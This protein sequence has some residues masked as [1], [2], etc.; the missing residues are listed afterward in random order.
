MNS[1]IKVIKNPMDFGTLKRRYGHGWY[2]SVSHFLS[3]FKLIFSNCY[4]FNNPSTDVHSMARDLEIF[5]RK[6]IEPLE[7]LAAEE[8]KSKAK[9][10]NIPSKLPDS[11][12]AVKDKKTKP[13]DRKKRNSLTPKEKNTT[14]TKNR[15]TS[16]GKESK[17]ETELPQKVSNVAKFS[18]S[19]NA[20][21]DSRKNLITSSPKSTEE[22]NSVDMKRTFDTLNSKTQAHKYSKKASLRNS[23]SPRAKPAIHDSVNEANE[24]ATNGINDAAQN[25]DI[26]NKP[27]L[28]QYVPQFLQN[29]YSKSRHN[30]FDPFL[31]YS[32]KASDAMEMK[33]HMDCQRIL[34]ILKHP[35]L[36][37]IM[38]PFF[39][40][41]PETKY[42]DLAFIECSLAQGHYRTLEEFVTAIRHIFMN[43]ITQFDRT[44]QL[45]ELAHL[46]LEA[47]HD[48]YLNIL[49]NRQSILSLSNLI[50]NRSD[51][52][53]SKDRQATISDNSDNPA[54]NQTAEVVDD[55][56]FIFKSQDSKIDELYEFLMRDCEAAKNQVTSEQKIK[57]LD[58]R[59]S[60]VEKQ[61]STHKAHTNMTIDKLR[62]RISYLKSKQ[63]SDLIFIHESFQVAV[64]KVASVASPLIN[65][66]LMLPGGASATGSV[67]SA[68]SASTESNKYFKEKFKNYT[69]SK[70]IMPIRELDQM[71]QTSRSILLAGASK[72]DDEEESSRRLTAEEKRKLSHDINR[73]SQKML[74]ELIDIIAKHEGLNPE[75]EKELTLDYDKMKPATLRTVQRFVQSCIKRLPRLKQIQNIPVT[76]FFSEISTTNNGSTRNTGSTDSQAR[77]A[78]TDSAADISY[79]SCQ[80]DQ[81]VQT[82]ESEVRLPNYPYFQNAQQA[83]ANNSFDKTTQTSQNQHVQN[84]LIPGAVN[85]PV[86]AAT[87][88]SPIGNINKTLLNNH[89]INL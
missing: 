51:N 60:E 4:R 68:T 79:S 2:E 40:H 9:N 80:L 61:F 47:F 43:I 74:A 44:S 30:L 85:S 50:T 13:D 63:Q 7:I 34:Q 65:G 78:A 67:G 89:L 25:I 49:D 46:G 5:S 24:S 31:H 6:Y 37:P 1:T 56:N 23:L 10:E 12:I 81:S 88:N 45:V 58:K 54:N 82:P 16:L 28:H 22:S 59:L 77:N 71:E 20:P 36:S 76:N 86:S 15:K 27:D 39:N 11:D 14:A 8:K 73:L 19:E 21:R 84:S 29:S 62:K 66:Q 57:Q 72:S 87:L 70:G 17:I 38:W 64:K 83:A 18:K 32:T 55:Q 41:P 3:D 53:T 69:K 48:I 52:L 33:V 35:D 42:P 75:A 26:N